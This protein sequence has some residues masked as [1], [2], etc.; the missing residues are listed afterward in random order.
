MGADEVEMTSGQV[1]QALRELKVTFC[2]N[3]SWT[4]TDRSSVTESL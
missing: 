3:F 4:K 2:L 1:M